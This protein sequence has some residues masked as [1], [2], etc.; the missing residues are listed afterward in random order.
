[1]RE[2]VDKCWEACKYSSINYRFSKQKFQIRNLEA[3]NWFKVHPELES[4][5]SIPKPL[6]CP[7]KKGS[8]GCTRFQLLKGNKVCHDYQEINIQEST[9]VLGVGVEGFYY[10]AHD[11]E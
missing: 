2:V 7:S 6:I 4:R 8:C 10:N 1:M 3:D 11:F 9:Q 5:N